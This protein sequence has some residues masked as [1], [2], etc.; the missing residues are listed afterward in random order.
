MHDRLDFSIPPFIKTSWTSQ[1]ARDAWEQ[2]LIRITAAFSKIEVRSVLEGM[3]PACRIPASPEGLPAL[4][5][6]CL[7]NGLV[8]SPTESKTNLSRYAASLK[9]VPVSPEFH[10][11]VGSAETV[12]NT[13]WEDDAAVGAILGYPQCCVAFFEDVWCGQHYIDTSWPMAANTVAVAS[14]TSPLVIDDPLPYCNIFN[15]WASV[16]AVA[17]LPCS[18]KCEATQ[19]VGAA[20]V[21]LGR[22]LGHCQE[23]DDLEAVLSWPVEWRALHGVA[24][25]RSPLFR[26]TSNTDATA[27]TY[28][29]QLRGSSYPAEGAQGTVFPYKRNMGRVL[30]EGR[31]FRAFHTPSVREPWYYG[32][33]GFFSY[34]DQVDKHKPIIQAL[35]PHEP[36][37]VC[38]LGCGNGALL[39]ELSEQTG[40]Y[41]DKHRLTPTGVDMDENKIAHAQHLHP[42]HADRF[43]I[44]NF[45]EMPSLGSFD[46]ILL[47]INENQKSMAQDLIGTFA[48]LCKILCLYTYSDF[49]IGAHVASLGFE[50][51]SASHGDGVNVALVRG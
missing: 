17:H 50:P 13:D 12:G 15:R 14:P 48:P 32:D 47:S 24:E 39:L 37:T 46:A 1:R 45:H 34:I 28:V 36:E 21:Y 51:I 5:R 22:Q 27:S 11:L 23:M 26:I 4:S 10:V 40:L 33:N 42:E 20:F 8:A 38:D 35:A 19:E 31:S 41:N 44:G 3:R 30:T 25:V 7:K 16:R 2:R 29:V 6:Y 18:L 49:D 43:H 9:Q